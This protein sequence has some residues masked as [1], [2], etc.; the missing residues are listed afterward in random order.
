[1]TSYDVIVIGAG[2]AG[3][4]A[5]YKLAKQGRSVL[6][7]EKE[8]LPR[9]KPCGGGVPPVI[10][11]WFDFDLSPVVSEKVTE[12]RYTWQLGDVVRAQI[13]TVWMV[14]RDQF[15]HYLMQQAQHQGAV[16]RDSEPVLGITAL[17]T[18]WCVRTS[19]QDY[20]GRYLLGADGA[21][22]STARWLGLGQR[23]VSIGGAIEVEI[24]A[25]VPEAQ[26]AH[27]E[28]GLV[29]AGYL[30]NFPKQS[31]HSIGI[32]TFGKK[33]VDLKTPLANYVASFGLTLEG[34]I[35]HGHPLL[36]WQGATPLHTHHA[37]LAGESAGIVDPLTA[38]GI[39][40]ALHTGLLAATYLDRALAGD[41]H[42]LAHYTAHVHE[43]WGEDLDWAYRLAQVF[44]RWPELGYRLGVKR[45]S[46]TQRM[47][48]LL[49]G[50]VRYRDVA[51]RAL[52]RLNV[53]TQT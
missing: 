25:V 41:D 17:E 4:A 15:D 42:A 22:G 7:L 26:T 23:K 47:G 46:A 50:R 8:V 10:Q 35:L 2:P 27:F 14:R 11:E 33:K 31:G 5:A 38:E 13:E 3:G 9:Y 39:R 36:L 51:H 21:K 37:L 48:E 34:V 30:W 40:P 52:N 20:R 29:P 16:L 24:P 18:G 43:A 45:P 53:F 1:M 28:F 32:G 6:V 12:L 44:Y 49:S 19:Q